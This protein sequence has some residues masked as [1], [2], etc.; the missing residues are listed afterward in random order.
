MLQKDIVCVDVSAVLTVR[1]TNFLMFAGA[2]K[3]REVT[4]LF[5]VAKDVTPGEQVSCIYLITP[6]L[7][8]L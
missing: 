6:T 7:F 1:M 3:T 2:K 4:S 8:S 5:D